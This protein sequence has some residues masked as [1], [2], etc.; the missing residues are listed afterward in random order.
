MN[1]AIKK[2]IYYFL[3]GLSLSI[4]IPTLI[5]LSQPGRGEDSL[6][7]QLTGIGH[8]SALKL[9]L[10]FALMPLLLEGFFL[11]NKFKD[12]QDSA[13]YL[14]KFN[15]STLFTLNLL[16]FTVISYFFFS[17][18]QSSLFY[19][20]DGDY[21]VS[22]FYSQRVWNNEAS[23]F[24]SNFLQGLGGNII[25]PLNTIIDPAY[26]VAG[27]A[28]NLDFAFSH[29]IW[30]LLLFLSTFIFSSVIGLSFGISVLSAWIVPIQILF[31]QSFR[32]YSVA[33]LIPHISTSISV[34]LLILTLIWINRSKLHWLVIRFV[35]IS[36]LVI[37]L[38]LSNPSIV[39][40]ISPILAA[41][42]LLKICF[43]DS[44]KA[45]VSEGVM[46]VVTA[47]AI[48]LS[49]TFP[50][51]IGLFTNSAVLFF[52]DDFYV[53]RG[54]LIFGST[55]F[56][57]YGF[58]TVPFA[59]L[60]LLSL[61]RN[62]FNSRQVRWISF[63]SLIYASAILVAGLFN[64][65]Y[66]QLWPLPSPVYFEF[67]LWPIYCIGLASFVSDLI[68]LLHG[69]I[70]SRLSGNYRR[71]LSSKLLITCLPCFLLASSL[72]L[73][74]GLKSSVQRSWLF[75]PPDSEVMSELIRD[76]SHKPGDQVKGRVATFTGMNL[77]NGVN[78]GDLQA[79]DHSLLSEIDNDMRKAG[80]W[81]NSIP[82]L[83]EY[84]SHITPRFYYLTTQFLAR[85]GD[86]Q[87]RSMMT[88]RSL[89]P[90]ILEVLGIT[91][92]VTDSI[93]NSLSLLASDQRVESPIY[94]YK[95]EDS[96]VSGFS[97][98]NVVNPETIREAVDLMRSDDF[99][100]K[101]TVTVEKSLN[102]DAELVTATESKITAHDG[103]YRVTAKS[104]GKS[105]L[106]LPIE[107][108]SCFDVTNYGSPDS[109]LK[110]F[111]GNTLLM[112]VLFNN[113]LDIDLKYSNGP[114]KNSS[115]RLN[116]YDEFKQRF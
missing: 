57:N 103:F 30:A 68:S 42:A 84:N 34:T 16:L 91:H 1:N 82:T 18:Y 74:S 21:M 92:V 12:N 28:G 8:G 33:S 106:V 41:F 43:Y 37:Y 9:A 66:P 113:E 64:W 60:G 65:R 116:D 111:P 39:L 90:K 29:V 72:V 27:L 15:L 6:L 48:S 50:F 23:Y 115:C 102:L 77:K 85:P 89:N 62:K 61:N 104:S 79:Y 58:I 56:S 40:L 45:R 10:F 32:F 52:P 108:S 93:N 69:F 110:V 2:P 4:F 81:I 101:S 73:Y 51:F 107:Y 49:G 25:F 76:L 7:F 44:A 86:Q 46:F 105:I 109:L 54:S 96:N 17:K 11:I 99:D 19:G 97:P 13:P 94:L 38:F 24:T 35:T 83:T 70:Q 98:V 87:V 3:I 26:F 55:F 20:V 80:F 14:S 59:I 71:F 5:S 78:W 100:F 53:D 114:F 63:G 67:Y 75:P 22:L 47:L 88:L 36:L 112:S 95:L 31:P